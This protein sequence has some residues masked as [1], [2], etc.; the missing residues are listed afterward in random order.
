M[1]LP[2]PDDL[3]ADCL[4]LPA[5]EQDAALQGLCRDYPALAEQLRQRFAALQSLGLVG[6]ASEQS[7]F[8]QF[9][10]DFELGE[11]LGDGGMGVVYLARQLSL[12]RVAVVKWIRNDLLH[13]DKARLR[14]QR[15]AEAASRLKHPGIV[16]IHLV[17]DA[18]GKPFIAMEYV[19]G[20]NLAERMQD[21]SGR[22]PESLTGADLAPVF[23][24]SWADAVLDVG[25]QVAR[26]LQHAHDNGILHRDIK[27]SNIMLS[28]DGRAQVVD[29]GLHLSAG[30][31]DD[32]TQSG[33][34]GTLLYMPPEQLRGGQIDQRSEVYA[35]AATLYEMLCLQPPFLGKDRKATE[36]LV[37]AGG[38]Q[39]LKPRNRSLPSDAETVILKALAVEPN[40]RYASLN[41][42]ADDLQRVREHKPVFAKPAGAMYRFRRWAQRQPGLA[43]TSALLLIALIAA[44]TWI[45][46][47]QHQTTQ[48]LQNM[49]AVE[50][51]A[52]T[53]AEA[54]SGLILQLF[55]Q[56]DPHDGNDK[57]TLGEVFV[58]DL[59]TVEEGL[60][61]SPRRLALLLSL[62]G[63]IQG[64]MGLQQEAVASLQRAI[65]LLKQQREQL[66]LEEGQGAS[67]SLPVR[68]QDMDVDLAEAYDRLATVLI[69]EAAVES[70][71]EILADGIEVMERAYGPE[72]W[73]TQLMKAQ[74]FEMH[75]TKVRPFAN[76]QFPTIEGVLNVSRAALA[77]MEG[78]ADA[79]AEERA[80]V[81]MII[82]S[83]ILNHA[84]GETD[85]SKRRQTAQDGLRHLEQCRQ[86]LADA[87]LNHTVQF[88][89]ALNGMGMGNHYAWELE[90]AELYFEQALK[91]AVRRLGPEHFEV[92]KFLINHGQL[93]RSQ[94]K[95]EE[96]LDRIQRGLEIIRLNH[97]DQDGDTL[98]SYHGALLQP[99]LLALLDEL[100]E[101]D[102]LLEKY[103]HVEVLQRKHF[104]DNSP[105]LEF[106]L[107]QILK[108]E[109]K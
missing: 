52:R 99:I 82:G 78:Q 18:D 83:F 72:H 56:A 49:Y 50:K 71:I 48:R 26:A 5:D 77:A 21:L 55:E 42:F 95:M 1:K 51:S 105:H 17:G 28:R 80:R 27:P 85:Q 59:A 7:E 66:Q 41:H 97:P 44:P 57:R 103:R 10:A 47:Q 30:N 35:L 40:R 22:S 92:S 43:V 46:W 9:F 69:R 102:G 61:E 75:H 4:Q 107:N 36:A 6:L 54:L 81:H 29:F 16:P 34:L 14:F 76:G 11:K 19:D 63:R 2:E 70:A 106:T 100:G 84:V 73:R 104:G 8:P 79:G 45:I 87:G 37:L 91:I 109:Q 93:N 3:L 60:H 38:P 39:P 96:A 53:E 88:A 98:D 20:H 23:E 108:L 94:G 62:A 24:Q 33:T 64:H 31:P 68:M 13:V 74:L 15:E 58:H 90:S 89:L 86:L 67:P 101:H 25:I 32:A 12:D 65:A